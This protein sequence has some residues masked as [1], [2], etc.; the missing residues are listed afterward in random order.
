MRK[1]K[2]GSVLV[3]ISVA[4]LGCSSE[5][6]AA[7][8]TGGPGTGATGGTGPPATALSL[9]A[10]TALPASAGAAAA[11][12]FGTQFGALM[13][14]L[15]VFGG[16]SP[17]DAQ[18]AFA[19]KDTFPLPEFC[20]DG[21]SASLDW[22]GILVEDATVIV[23]LQNCQRSPLLSDPTSG[24][25][26]FDVDRAEGLVFVGAATLDLQSPDGVV[27]GSFSVRSNVANLFLGC[28]LGTV[29]DCEPAT[30]N[31]TA[32]E[33]G[34]QVSLECFE[35]Y[36]RYPEFF[37]PLAVVTLDDE[38]LAL[39]NKVFTINNYEATPANINFDVSTGAPIRGTVRL[40][41]GVGPGAGG[42]EM[43]CFN[44]MPAGDN[45]FC[46][47]T[48]NADGC[49]D[50]NCPNDDFN[51][52]AFW[53]DLLDFDFMGASEEPCGAGGAGGAAGQ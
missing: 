51:I 48:F 46:D 30:D 23:T 32:T 6:S 49:V 9:D 39:D 44:G 28:G 18:G 21:G 20:T 42:P 41:S 35:I 16:L 12:A 4:C 31:V 5:D 19:P 52:S 29:P 38:V 22:G 43:P 1:T 17:R 36:Q 15:G 34:Q 47:L 24:T 26:T 33:G 27:A 40:V 14:N 3:A 37:R 13:S 2:L 53:D 11:I 10:D 50:I 8:G 45:S 7:G 25:I